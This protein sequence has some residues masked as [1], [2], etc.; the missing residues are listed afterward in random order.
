[1]I[2]E[3]RTARQMAK[4]GLFSL[5]QLGCSDF[6]IVSCGSQSVWMECGEVSGVISLISSPLFVYL[7]GEVAVLPAVCGSLL[8]GDEP[9]WVSMFSHDG[10]LALLAWVVL[11]Y[12]F[13][14][15]T[16][17]VFLPP[18]FSWSY[19]FGGGVFSLLPREGLQ[20]ILHGFFF[21]GA[22]GG[23]PYPLLFWWDS[24]SRALCGLGRL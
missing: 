10:V 6:C 12:G 14:S 19:L 23:I 5:G 16:G 20:T 18:L 9:C 1:M 17:G 4:G 15:G 13:L 11:S 22:V 3:T 2:Q 7:S 8:T 24:R 21:F